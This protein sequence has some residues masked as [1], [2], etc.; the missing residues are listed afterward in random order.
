V[1]ELETARGRAFSV[2]AGEAKDTLVIDAQDG[3]EV[4]GVATDASWAWVRRSPHGAIL[5]F[6]V[7]DGRALRVNG[8]IL[9]RA[10]DVV[11]YVAGRSV[12]G[13]WRLETDYEGN[14]MVPAGT[15]F[16]NPCAVSA[17]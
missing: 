17:E 9:F 8:T 5:E 1:A 2:T 15:E 12:D 11:R 6:V 4:D 7:L 3:A 13:E 10:E 14:L 16:S